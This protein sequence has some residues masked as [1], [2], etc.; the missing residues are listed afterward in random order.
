DERLRRLLEEADQLG[1]GP[2]LFEVG[3]IGHRSLER[4]AANG[5]FPNEVSSGGEEVGPELRVIRPRSG[6]ALRQRRRV[7]LEERAQEAGPAVPVA[8]IADPAEHGDAREEEF[9]RHLDGEQAGVPSFARAATPVSSG[10]GK[11]VRS[12]IGRNTMRSASS[13]I[14]R[15]KRSYWARINQ[16]PK[17]ATSDAAR[18]SI[19]NSSSSRRRMRFFAF[20]TVR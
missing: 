20:G 13:P 17:L 5:L 3:G 2:R 4:V 16:S 14:I 19:R 9:R 15:W 8:G 11:L 7:H 18:T 12:A 6:E 10:R 1:P